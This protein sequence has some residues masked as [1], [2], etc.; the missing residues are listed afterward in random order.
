MPNHDIVVI[1]A[2]AG[3]V[4][5]LSKLV[6]GLPAHLPAAVFVV[7]HV[8]AHGTSV[9]PDILSRAGPLGATHAKD[10]Q[11]I[12]SGH[13]FVAPPDCHLLLEQGLIRLSR[14]PKE[15]AARPAIDPLF[16]SA[17]LH[18]RSRVVGV[19]LSG[20]LGDGTAGLL[21]IKR[22]GGITA[23]QD[24]AEALYAGMPRNA[25]EHVAVDHVLPVAGIGP[26]VSEL[27]RT[28]AAPPPEGAG[29]VSAQMAEETGFAE[30]DLATIEGGKHP[31]RPSGF[32]CPDCGGALWEMRDH[33]LIRFRCRVGHAWAAEALLAEQTE[34]LETALWT[35]LR[36]L[37][38][39]AAL[40]RDLAARLRRRGA[41]AAVRFEEQAASAQQHATT[42]RRLLLQQ[43]PASDRTEAPPPAP[44]AAEGD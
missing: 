41:R 22:R 7:L 19:V 42:I 17:A 3:G 8:P 2:S 15:N 43:V 38:E 1:G 40:A 9:L 34:A 39:R 26:L 12:Q 36:S 20:V 14:G 6:S 32:G 5:A 37:E 4:E 29:A 18:Y 33:D 11:G 27:A 30:F 23:V 24:P 28:P 16:R 35:A 10:G 21:A 31:G 44:A 13:I 25:M